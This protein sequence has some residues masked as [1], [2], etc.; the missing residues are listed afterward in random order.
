MTLQALNTLIAVG[1]TTVLFAMIFK[2][3][4]SVPLQWHDVWVGAA[5]TAVLFELGKFAIGYYLG[6]SGVNET[7]A[8]AGSLVV[9]LA[10]VYYAAQIF[11]LGAEFTKGVCRRARQRSGQA[12][13]WPPRRPALWW[14]QQ[15]QTS[16][17]TCC[18]P[19]L[20]A[21]PRPQRTATC[22]RRKCKCWNSAPA[23]SVRNCGR[24]LRWCWHSRCAGI[25]IAA[26][27]T[28]PR[29]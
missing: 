26:K 10:W 16:P 23:S 22:C 29:P 12:M 9:V 11:L 7:Y 3:M 5:V 8:A 2:F 25:G 4:P 1:A 20:R 24:W 13:R 17:P 28:A 19:H 6:K 14:R 15:A 27:R 18:P 21:L